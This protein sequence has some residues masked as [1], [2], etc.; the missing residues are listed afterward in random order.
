M[1]QVLYP[2]YAGFIAVYAIIF[3]TVGVSVA[4]V[5]DELFPKFNEND[6]KNKGKFRYYIEVLIQIALIATL[7][8]VFR[9]IIHFLFTRVK[10]I[11]KHMY[12]NPDRFAVLVIPTTM[13]AA[14]PNLINKIKY[15]WNV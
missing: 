12:G 8:Y 5:L 11:K 2:K 13:F 9:E 14:Q 4:R 1:S 7:T 15:I 3:L 6:K 10:G